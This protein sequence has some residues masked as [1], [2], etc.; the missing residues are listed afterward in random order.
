MFTK[1]TDGWWNANEFFYQMHN[2]D[3]VAITAIHCLVVHTVEKCAPDH[4][5]KWLEW[6]G[7][8]PSSIVRCYPGHMQ[9]AE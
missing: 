3:V 9:A 5:L 6:E 4:C 1:L 2:F 8:E 7:V